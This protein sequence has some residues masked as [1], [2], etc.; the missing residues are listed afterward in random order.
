[1]YKINVNYKR[2]KFTHLIESSDPY[3]NKY[4]NLRFQNKQN[5][6]ARN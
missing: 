4:L 2:I 6:V 3:N 5:G 1:M